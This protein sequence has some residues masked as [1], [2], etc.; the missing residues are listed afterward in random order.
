MHALT[1][2]AKANTYSHTPA[3]GTA[4]NTFRARPPCEAPGDRDPKRPPAS[5]GRPGVCL[6][7]V[8]RQHL[9][10][11]SAASSSPRRPKTNG[12]FGSLRKWGRPAGPPTGR[13]RRAC[14]GAPPCGAG[15][16]R[17]RGGCA[18][19]PGAGSSAPAPREPRHRP[20]G[21]QTSS[22]LSLAAKT[23]LFLSQ[24]VQALSDPFA[25][26]WPRGTRPAGAA[27]AT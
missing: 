19:P 27:A 14:A 3:L 22:S 6:Q 2:D 18:P 24:T 15:S 16:P 10:R 5:T 11:F 9:E 4:S 1:I 12:Y 26:H 20:R 17:G 13:T 7:E 23:Y 25:F 8:P 21:A